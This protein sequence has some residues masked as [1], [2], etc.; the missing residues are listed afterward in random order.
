MKTNCRIN[1][2]FLLQASLKAINL[3]SLLVTLILILGFA[4][5]SA[6]PVFGVRLEPFF[7]KALGIAMLLV[8]IFLLNGCLSNRLKKI[9]KNLPEKGG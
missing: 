6:L 7:H 4:L 9:L 1:L 8:T 3:I 5:M 2:R